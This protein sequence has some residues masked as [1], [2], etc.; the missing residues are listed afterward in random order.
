MKPFRCAASCSSLA[1]V[2][3]GQH[4]GRIRL[5]RQ[6]S[7]FSGIWPYC[8]NVPYAIGNNQAWK[9]TK[10]FPVEFGLCDIA[11]N[12]ALQISDSAGSDVRETEVLKVEVPVY[13]P[14]DLHEYP[15]ANP[16]PPAGLFADDVSFVISPY[17][18]IRTEIARRFGWIVTPGELSTWAWTRFGADQNYGD[19]YLYACYGEICQSRIWHPVS[20]RLV[21]VKRLLDS[22]GFEYSRVRRGVL[23]YSR[24][25]GASEFVK[26]TG[27]ELND[28]WEI[29]AAVYR[30]DDLS[31]RYTPF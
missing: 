1:R 3:Y 22:A 12:G 28:L 10:I 9:D 30:R 5:Y 26:A 19:R 20:N 21:T 8:E 25:D 13:R 31:L 23:I 18:A 29:A 2:G 15:F 17:L 14:V 4:V 27:D 6:V 11:A 16:A 7:S 24:S